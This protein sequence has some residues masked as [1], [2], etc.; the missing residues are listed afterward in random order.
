MEVDERNVKKKQRYMLIGLENLAA[1][2]QKDE[3][4]TKDLLRYYQGFTKFKYIKESFNTNANIETL[5]KNMPQ[6]DIA[7]NEIRMGFIQVWNKKLFL[8][9]Y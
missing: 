6:I 5:I 8:G 2:I 3:E 4:L 1:F 7:D 9:G